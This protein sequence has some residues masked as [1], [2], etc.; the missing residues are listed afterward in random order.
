[1]ERPTQSNS[2]EGHNSFRLKSESEAANPLRSFA[3]LGS[4]EPVAA[5]SK[6]LGSDEL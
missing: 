3:L 4:R 5:R 2:A 1:M 6:A